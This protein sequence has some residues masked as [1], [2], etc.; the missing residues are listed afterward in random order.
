MRRLAASMDRIAGPALD[1]SGFLEAIKGTK[2][3]QRTPFVANLHKLA[4]L[5]PVIQHLCELSVLGSRQARDI[6][7]ICAPRASLRGRTWE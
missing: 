3:R 1:E 7:S 4:S 2:G 5:P 6:R